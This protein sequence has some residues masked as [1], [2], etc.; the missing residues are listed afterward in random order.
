MIGRHASKAEVAGLV[1]ALDRPAAPREPDLHG[2]IEFLL[3]VILMPKPTKKGGRP[4][5]RT[6]END[7]KLL[8]WFTALR[9]REEDASG[10]ALTDKACVLAFAKRH[11]SQMNV[12]P[13]TIINW[14]QEAKKRER[15]KDSS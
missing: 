3:A 12:K 13:K 15:L 1:R 10:C 9:Q 4:P 6:A 11:K 14:L 8:E 5:T 2:F 7:R